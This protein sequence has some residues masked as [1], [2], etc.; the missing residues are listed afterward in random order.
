LQ[1]LKNY[2][3][4]L[5][6]K[7]HITVGIIGYPNT[8][9]S[10]LIN[11]MK[12][13]KAVAVGATPGLTKALQEVKLDKLISLIDSPGVMF[14]SARQNDPDELL[15]RN[16]LRV[17]QLQDPISAVYAVVRRC[18]ETALREAYDIPPFHDADEFIALVAVKRGKLG[19]GGVPDLE[20]AAR[21]IIKDWNEG[22]IRYFS[23]P[24]QDEPTASAASASSSSGSRA[25]DVEILS[26]FSR[27]FDLK[28]R[29]VRVEHTSGADGDEGAMDQ[30][31]GAIGAKEIIASDQDDSQDEGEQSD[32]MDE[33]SSSSSSVVPRPVRDPSSSAL[34]AS[35][36][37]MHTDSTPSATAAPPTSSFIQPIPASARRNRALK[38]AQKREKKQRE[39]ERQQEMEAVHASLGSVSLLVPYQPATAGDAVPM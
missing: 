10:S 27:E 21:T 34:A 7:K 13:S 9:K 6:M 23:M 18:T 2:S 25:G 37:A 14:D 33:S 38:Q 29:P 24:P 22:K 17:E 16:C 19:R 32:D 3:R 8:G 31:A 4:T 12:R 28:S 1:L 5:N 26:E 30:E 39:Q 35:S 20:S 36:D 15:L 11:S